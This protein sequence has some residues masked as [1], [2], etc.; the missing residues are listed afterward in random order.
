[1][2]R[3]ARSLRD[4]DGFTLIEA[5]VASII[6]IIIMAAFAGSMTSA[7]RGSRLT[8]ANQSA[9]ALGVEHLEFARSLSWDALAMTH[10]PAESPHTGS[11]GTVLTAHAGGLTADEVLVVSA[12]GAIQP[13]LYQGVGTTDY[14]VWQYVTDAGL[15]LRRVVVIITWQHGDA[16]FTHRAAT[17]ISEVSTR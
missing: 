17:L 2:T 4:D 16:T 14:T 15:G 8:H 7:F 11:G 5:L 6:A 10:V 12:S 13:L 3:P 1:M 9:T